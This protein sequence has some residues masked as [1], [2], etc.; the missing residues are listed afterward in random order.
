MIWFSMLGQWPLEKPHHV[1]DSLLYYGR[2][3]WQQTLHD[4]EN[5]LDVAYE[6]VLNEFDLV[7]CVKGLIVSRS[8]LSI[9]W[10]VRPKRA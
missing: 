6:V 7:W 8:N 10:K 2:L 9:S 4:L 1:W 5:A 3:R